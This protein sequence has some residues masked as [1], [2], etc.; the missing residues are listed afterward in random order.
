MK[1]KIKIGDCYQDAAYD[2]V[3]IVSNAIGGDC[4]QL[5]GKDTFGCLDPSPWRMLPTLHLPIGNDAKKYGGK[6]FD[7]IRQKVGGKKEEYREIAGVNKTYKNVGLLTN[8]RASLAQYEA[9]NFGEVYFEKL[10][11]SG[12]F[13]FKPW[14]VLHITNGY[15]HDKPQLCTSRER[16]NSSPPRRNRPCE[17]GAHLCIYTVKTLRQSC[18]PSQRLRKLR[19]LRWI[20]LY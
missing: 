15:G 12:Q 14:K 9:E 17:N 7:M 13:N 19:L 3:F 8:C 2:H 6:W 11:K 10:L 1:Q 18:Q 5:E 16:L 4:V 20:P